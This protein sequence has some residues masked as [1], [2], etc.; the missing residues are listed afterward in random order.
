VGSEIGLHTGIR[1]LRAWQRMRF[2]NASGWN[3][4]DQTAGAFLQEIDPGGG[5]VAQNNSRGHQIHYVDADNIALSTNGKVGIGTRTPSQMLHVYGSTNP[6]ILVEAPEATTPE[7]NPQAP[8][9]LLQHVSEC[10]P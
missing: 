2:T 10:H 3:R 8:F 9:G 1:N 6:R 7:L 5:V 4:F